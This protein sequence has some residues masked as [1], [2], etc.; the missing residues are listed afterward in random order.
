MA[1]IDN[2]DGLRAAVPTVADHEPSITTI[3][4]NASVY[5]CDDCDCQQP[6][7]DCVCWLCCGVSNLIRARINADSGSE[8]ARL[9]VGYP[10]DSPVDLAMREA[11]AAR[12]SY[13]Q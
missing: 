3:Y 8:L 6:N 10:D 4:I 13:E 1:Y 7:H 5:P 9:D 12:E 11:R 2:D